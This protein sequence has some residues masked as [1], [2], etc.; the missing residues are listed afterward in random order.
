[1][2]ALLTNFQ[3]SLEVVRLGPFNGVCNKLDW[4]GFAQGLAAGWGEA[5]G[6]F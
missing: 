4:L 3:L 2:R 5:G 6:G 1:M